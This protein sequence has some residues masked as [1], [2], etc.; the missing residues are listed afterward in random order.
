MEHVEGGK[1]LKMEES[2]V[3]SDIDAISQPSIDHEPV[4]PVFMLTGVN[5][6]QRPALAS[7][8]EKLGG[9]Y[10]DSDDWD[11]RCTHLIAEKITK[12]EKCLAAAAGGRW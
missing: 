5:R 1:R 10:I 8:I 3:L 11:N 6:E 4:Q 2:I 12:T 9:I 7:I